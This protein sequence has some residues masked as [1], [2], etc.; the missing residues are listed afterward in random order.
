M[1]FIYDYD[2][3]EEFSAKTT[4]HAFN[5]SVLPGRGRRRDDFLDTEAFEP[6]LNAST[7]NAIAVSQ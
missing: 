4:N 7:I 5:I 3:I 1:S 2:V 6:P